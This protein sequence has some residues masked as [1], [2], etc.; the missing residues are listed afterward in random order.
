[1]ADL[2]DLAAAL[3]AA[4]STPSTYSNIGNNLGALYG[5]YDRKQY[6]DKDNV[7]AALGIGLAQGLFGG[8]GSA[9]E[10][11]QQDL[12][13]SV[14][15]DVAAGGEP[16]KP[17][18]LSSKLFS[19]AIDQGSLFKIKRDLELQ[20]EARKLQQ[21]MGSKIFDFG[22]QKDLETYKL[23]RGEQMDLLK[24]Y[25]ANPERVKQVLGPNA[26]K[27]IL[28]TSN[29][30]ED[31]ETIA[32]IE[33]PSLKSL[34]PQ[35]PSKKAPE[36]RFNELMG[37]TGGE[38]GAAEKILTQ[39]MET[40]AKEKTALSDEI[41]KLREAIQTADTIGNDLKVALSAAGE[42]G[43]VPYLEEA[44][45]ELK[46]TAKR[47]L[48]SEEARNRMAGRRDLKDLTQTYASTL[49]NLFPGPVATKELEMWMA[50]SPGTG[51]TPEENLVASDR[52]ERAKVVAKKSADFLQAAADAGLDYGRASALLAILNEK[53]PLFITTKKGVELNP[54]RLQ[55]NMRDPR[56][57]QALMGAK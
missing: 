14:L 29:G 33:T 18:G 40:Q 19:T 53:A 57:I 49:R 3:A 56:L 41:K 7:L 30:S 47:A 52:L 25:L 35:A 38:K 13:R 15:A 22:L 10:A 51:R 45:R 23:D 9:S 34:T 21:K 12:F 27:N 43:G 46:L 2:S 28:G 55:L 17:A 24:E 20:D 48:G 37:K 36:E 44:G 32:A 26:L 54:L 6:S 42:T 31:G 16:V 4:Q 11:N 5:S 39:E 1:M 8:L 50:A